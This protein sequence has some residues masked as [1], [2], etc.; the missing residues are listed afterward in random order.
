MYPTSTSVPSLEP[1]SICR[2]SCS[3]K[4]THWKLLRIGR[5]AL[6]REPVPRRYPS[7]A[8]PPSLY[9]FHQGQLSS[10]CLSPDLIHGIVRCPPIVVEAR[11]TI[12]S[13]QVIYGWERLHGTGWRSLVLDRP[14]LGLISPCL[15]STHAQAL[16]EERGIRVSARLAGH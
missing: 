3:V 8:E 12:R 11:G 15:V 2:L 7:S 6:R 16:V 9:A 1:F 14:L 4:Y 10:T 5:T 13:L